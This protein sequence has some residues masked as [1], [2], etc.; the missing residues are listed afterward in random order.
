MERMHSK[1]LTCSGD[2]HGLD[3]GCKSRGHQQREAGVGVQCKNFE[4]G[5]GVDS[6]LK[7]PV[8]TNWVQVYLQWVWRRCKS[9]CELRWAAK[10]DS[11]FHEITR[12]G[13]EGHWR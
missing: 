6:T 12:A 2:L 9:T 10:M 13:Q 5:A 11:H 8:G 1:G 7:I 4:G 3:R